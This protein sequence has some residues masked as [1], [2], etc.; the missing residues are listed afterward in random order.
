MKACRNEQSRWPG[1]EPGPPGRRTQKRSAVGRGGDSPHCAGEV[2]WR[3]HRE[4]P[5]APLGTERR[6]EI[7]THRALSPWAGS[8]CSKASFRF[9]PSRDPL[10]HAPRSGS[11]A[12]A[13]RGHTR[14]GPGAHAPRGRGRGR[15]ASRR[16]FLRGREGAPWRRTGA[17]GPGAWRSR[18]LC[19]LPCNLQGPRGGR[20]DEIL[21]V[22]FRRDR[23]KRYALHDGLVAR[24][25]AVDPRGGVGGCGALCSPVS[26]PPPACASVDPAVPCSCH[27]GSGLSLAKACWVLQLTRLGRR[28]GSWHCPPPGRRSRPPDQHL[29]PEPRSGLKANVPASP[30]KGSGLRV[31]LRLSF[32]SG[33][34][35]PWALPVT[36]VIALTA[37]RASLHSGVVCHCAPRGRGARAAVYKQPG[38]AGTASHSSL[39]PCNDLAVTHAHW[40]ALAWSPNV[41]ALPQLPPLPAPPQL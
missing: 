41:P 31:A 28:A 39:A 21:R 3:K 32:S 36:T 25:P 24:R 18:S 37:L 40:L 4:A 14:P 17:P 15:A 30:R 23:A 27:L 13:G 6:P 1:A 20:R 16:G 29:H 11:G 8:T 2:T 33:T 38:L 35:R 9:C 34:Q 10:A 26:W 5:A 22:G 7:E 19:V 12:H